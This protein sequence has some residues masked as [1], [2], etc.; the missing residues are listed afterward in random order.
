MLAADTSFSVTFALL[1]GLDDVALPLMPF[2]HAYVARLKVQLKRTPNANNQLPP[3]QASHVLAILQGIAAS[4]KYPQ[5][6]SACS[7]MDHEQPKSP[8]QGPSGQQAASLSFGM[9]GMGPPSPSQVAA[10]A[11][12]QQDVEEKRR[13][14]FILFRNIAKLAFKET[15]SFV[16]SLLQHAAS[17]AVVRGREGGGGEGGESGPGSPDPLIRAHSSPSSLPPAPQSQFQHVE[18]AV[19]LLYEMGEGVPDEALK[20]D[21][22]QLGT[23]AAALMLSPLPSARHRLV[24]LAV[25]ETY[26]RYARVLQVGE[27]PASLILVHC[28]SPLSLIFYSLTPS[29]LFHS[30]CS[31]TLMPWLQRS[32]HSSTSEAWVILQRRFQ[33]E[34]VTY[35]AGSSRLSGHH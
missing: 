30:P 12:E 3:E 21:G 6:E 11:E 4:A 5:P 22:G 27:N 28:I 35:S 9:R 8:L 7:W 20:P 32:P 25:L 18:I 13:D 1:S 14:L 29:A 2:M 33:L 19:V 15:L 16:G 34:P 24:A 23:M 31:H 10:A 17:L 26:V